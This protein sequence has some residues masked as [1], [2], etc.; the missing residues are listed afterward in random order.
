MCQD[1]KGYLTNSTGLSLSMAVAPVSTNDDISKLLLSSVRKETVC[2][3]CTCKA[4]NIQI[5][6]ALSGS[7]VATKVPMLYIECLLVVLSNVVNLSITVE[8]LLYGHYE[9]LRL[10]V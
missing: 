6:K 9:P 4:E 10:A 5:R 8:P 7:Q 2:N 1:I 3:Y